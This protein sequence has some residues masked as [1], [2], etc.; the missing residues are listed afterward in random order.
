MAEELKF[1]VVA[2][3]RIIVNAAEKDLVVTQGLFA[4]FDLVEP[5]AEARA[6]SGGKYVS[7]G[8]SV[9]LKDRREMARLDEELKLV[10]VLRKL[11]E[12]AST[13]AMRQDGDGEAKKIQLPLYKLT[14]EELDRMIV[15]LMANGFTSFAE[16]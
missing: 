8:L 12:L 6:S 1:P 9:R 15:R 2:H 3:H 16:A 7:F 14:C 4:T 10:S 13:T 5:V 11:K